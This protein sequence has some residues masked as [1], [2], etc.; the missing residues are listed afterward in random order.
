[1]GN[2]TQSNQGRRRFLTGVGLVGAAG[3]SLGVSPSAAAQV[4]DARQ[5]SFVPARHE[6]DSWLEAG[7]VGHRA[8][9]D[10]ST[11]LGG[12]TALNYANNILTGHGEGYGGADSDYSLIV[13][14]RHQST[15]FGYGDS[16]WEK[17][18]RLLS[19]F[20]GLTDSR[21]NE[22]FTRNPLNMDRADMANRGN[23]ID[24]M[25]ARGVKFA[26]CNKATRSISG[27]LART[28][29]GE[30]DA[31]YQELAAASITASRFVPAG[32]LAATRSQEYG[33]SL[34]YA[35]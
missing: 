5:H 23:T 9:I 33:Y 34:L 35:G 20:M 24:M 27:V 16:I 28:G 21:T 3:A 8:F 32:V 31:I 2:N 10:S 12:T 11:T 19:G 15:P 29:A 4:S 25:V 7:N 30:A 13:C 1:M 22:P 18:G 26:I 17:Y 6:E 14:F